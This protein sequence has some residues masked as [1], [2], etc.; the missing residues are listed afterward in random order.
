VEEGGV[1]IT[2][3]AAVLVLEREKIESAIVETDEDR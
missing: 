2:L 1:D 3:D